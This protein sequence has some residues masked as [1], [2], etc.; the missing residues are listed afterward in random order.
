MKLSQGKF[1]EI[2]S[3][4]QQNIHRWET[5]IEPPTHFLRKFRDIYPGSYDWLLGIPNSVSKERI[6]NL[7]SGS[8]HKQAHSACEAPAGQIFIIPPL[9]GPVKTL[10]DAKAAIAR[11]REDVCRF[12][13]MA[14]AFC[15]SH[16]YVIDTL[17]EYI[18]NQEKQ[19]QEKE[20]SIK[21]LKEMAALKGEPG[22][23]QESKSDCKGQTSGNAGKAPPR[24]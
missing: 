5:T 20:A 12:A 19:N 15:N 16:R 3:E 17:G 21:R 9:P 8:G 22:G 11:S 18:A 4:K 2:F 13:G 24:E 7:K 23:Q 14:E 1:A 6:A 10:E